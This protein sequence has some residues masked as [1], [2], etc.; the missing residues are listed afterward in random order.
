M[1]WNAADTRL[2]KP[3]PKQSLGGRY[4]L[5][6]QP[7]IRGGFPFLPGSGPITKL[8]QCDHAFTYRECGCFR[9]I[10]SKNG[11]RI[12]HAHMGDAAA[13][14]TEPDWH[15]YRL[16]GRVLVSMSGEGRAE[17]WGG[18]PGRGRSTP[19]VASDYAVPGRPPTP[20]RRSRVP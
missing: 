10:G 6:E 4:D 20:G 17:A 2:R 5:G 11:E 18:S 12:V 16:S 1:T 15:G 7:A 14:R 19:S 9:V 3:F 8:A 13:F